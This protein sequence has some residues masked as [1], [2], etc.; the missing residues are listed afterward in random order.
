MNS[1][2]L[3]EYLLEVGNHSVYLGLLEEYLREPYTIESFVVCIVT[4][5][6]MVTSLILVPIDE[7]LPR[8]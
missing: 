7:V 3:G 6:E 8:E 1:W 2:I 5:G 4:P